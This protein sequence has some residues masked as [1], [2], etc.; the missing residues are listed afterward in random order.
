MKL[1]VELESGERIEVEYVEF[2]SDVL[3]PHLKK[4][5]I[6]LKTYN[7]VYYKGKLCFKSGEDKRKFI[8]SGYYIVIPVKNIKTIVEVEV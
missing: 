6:A 1:L 3:R 7:S 2:G 5:E 8:E 4:N